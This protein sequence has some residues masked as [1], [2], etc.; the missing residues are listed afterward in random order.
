[1]DPQAEALPPPAVPPAAVPIGVP[2]VAGEG[3]ASQ[4]RDGAALSP[5]PAGKPVETPAGG[6][7]R[8]A[9]GGRQRQ[10]LVRLTDAEHSELQARASGAGVSVQ[11]LLVESVLARDGITP[12]ERRALYATL[13]AARRTLAGVANNL[14]QL[15]RWTHAHETAHPDIDTAIETVEDAAARLVAAVAAVD[16]AV[17]D[18]S[19]R[20][21][22]GR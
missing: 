18:E 20:V 15:T 21:E 11:R 2:A 13:L 1:M 19:A 5:E 6:R 8:R 4:E 9:V 14:N 12:A 16:D 3:S 10:L 7:R 22:V 17:A